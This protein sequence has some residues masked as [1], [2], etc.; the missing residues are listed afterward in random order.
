MIFATKERVC[1][2]FRNKSTGMLWFSW[3]KCMYVVI[4]ATQVCVGCDF[5]DNEGAY[6]FL[7]TYKF[8]LLKSKDNFLGK[9][10]HWRFSDILSLYLAMKNPKIYQTMLKS[11]CQL[12]SVTVCDGT[13]NVK[14]YQYRYFFRYQIFPIP[15]LVHFSD[16]FFAIPVPIPP[17]RMKN[18]RSEYPL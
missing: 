6:F 5:S 12:R 4:F 10:S 3:Q 7:K 17:E 14:W 9:Y 18:S 13:Q 2:N 15:N 11:T 8:L 16:Q 1:C